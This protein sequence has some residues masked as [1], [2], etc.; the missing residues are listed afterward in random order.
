MS[1][2]AA[3]RGAATNATAKH[4]SGT[5]FDWD[6]ASCIHLAHVHA[7]NMG[8]D[9][10]PLPMFRTRQGALRALCKTGHRTLECLMDSLFPRIAPAQ[11]LVGD[12]GMLPGEDR[13]LRALVIY[14]G[15][16]SVAGWHEADPSSLVWIKN[17]QSDLIA[18]WRL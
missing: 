1:V 14:D 9:V 17:M 8:H 5:P 7:I 10:P 13:R 15:H 11:M 6:G 18:A 3:M 16:K 4:F 2:T 12:I